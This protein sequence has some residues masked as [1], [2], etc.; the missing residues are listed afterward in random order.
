LLAVC[1]A[2]LLWAAGFSGGLDSRTSLLAVGILALIGGLRDLRFLRFYL[3]DPNCQVPQYWKDAL[4]P[5]CT[6]FLWRLFNGSGLRTRY[7]YA[8]L[9]VLY[10]WVFLSGN[11]VWG[12][13]IL[14]SFGAA[15]GAALVAATE[16]IQRP[17]TRVFIDT[18]P[19]R[20]EL[21][22]SLSGLTLVTIGALLLLVALP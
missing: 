6:S 3:P 15:H 8:I 20:T 16:L 21:C 2:S 18:L 11:P 22:D 7:Q 14:G 1:G 5:Y 4:N 12:V 9:R 17:T 19:Q 10:L 13:T